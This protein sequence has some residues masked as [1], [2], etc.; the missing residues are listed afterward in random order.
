MM[1]DVFVVWGFVGTKTFN[2]FTG[3]FRPQGLALLHRRFYER[4]LGKNLLASVSKTTAPRIG[5]D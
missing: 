5:V 4:M 1:K 2:H 3:I